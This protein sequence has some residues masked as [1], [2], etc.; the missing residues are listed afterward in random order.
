M[1]LSNG[2][3]AD[4]K[5]TLLWGETPKSIN[6]VVPNIYIMKGQQNSSE[7]ELRIFPFFLARL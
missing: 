6:G 5:D 3:V 2:Q 7:M 4:V 1:L